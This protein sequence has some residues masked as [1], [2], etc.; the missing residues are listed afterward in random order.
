[1]TNL[2][3][4]RRRS[5][6]TRP[7][8]GAPVR[9]VGGLAWLAWIGAI[10]PNGALATEDGALLPNI[11]SR[12]RTEPDLR[13]PDLPSDEELE[14][15][16][17]TIGAI[18]ID[19]QNIF[20]TER[21][22]ENTALFR[23]GN[24]LHIRTREATVAQQLLFREGERYARRLLDESERILRSTR[25]LY[26]ARIR[27]VA[28]HDGRVDI[29]VRTRDVWTLNPGL[30]FGRSGGENSSGFEIEELNLLGLGTQ[31]SAGYKT[32]VDR[33][34]TALIYRDRQLFGSWWGISATAAENSDGNTRELAIDHPFFALD[35]RWTAGVS[36]ARDA[37]I[38]SFYDLGEV[39]AQ[40]EAR[41]SD[42][43]VF[44]GWSAGAHEGWVRRWTWGFTYAADR[45]D[46]LPSATETAFLPPDRKLAYP[47][48][49]FEL[50]QDEFYATRNRDQIEKTEDVALGWHAT[51]RL[52]WA[53]PSFGS[54]RTA[55]LF[56]GAVSKGYDLPGEHTLLVET[57]ASGRFE[58]GNLTN[59]I[60]STG[61][62]YYVRQSPR[63]LFF[64]TLQGEVSHDLD[65]DRQ[66]LLG[67][68]GGLRGYPLRYQGGE[69]RWLFT[70]EQRWF[71][72]WYPFRLFHVGG[73]AFYD[74]GRT[75]GTAPLASPSKGVL[76]DVGFGL[77][78]GNSRSGL[79]NIL[80]VDIAFPLDGD[81]SISNV[82]LL[83]E[84]KQSF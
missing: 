77:R 2:L 14:R 81:A 71:T 34:S 33:S 21:P 37:R 48:V 1:M 40:V 59:V 12:H 15:A 83:V 23:L 68:D 79:G 44:A 42:A 53:S 54:D 4:S 69:G 36:L 17:A 74:M 19:P 66:I 18:F 62:R 60:A 65:P 57:G 26:D 35:S 51:A 52:G 9:F 39:V 70:A 27:P 31:L 16:G 61:A 6:V 47:W 63:R 10:T 38:D 11:T 7:A 80:H 8:A 76:K 64:V 46:R 43:T 22:E 28:D 13:P 30:S 24:R 84:T 45:F 32:N 78:L 20:D 50:V 25:Y 41:E 3:A 75:W 72:D 82:Q 5:A 56:D 49:G 73:A 58:H 29:A 67:G 55:L